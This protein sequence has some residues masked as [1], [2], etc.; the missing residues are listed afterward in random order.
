MR[1]FCFCTDGV[2][3]HLTVAAQGVPGDVYVYGQGANISMRDWVD[4]ILRVGEEHGFWPG[5]RE[6]VSDRCA[7][8][9]GRE[10]GDGA[11]RRAREAHPGDR[12]AAARCRGRT[13]SCTRF[14]GTPRTANAGS[15]ASTGS[16][17]VRRS[18]RNDARSRHRRRRLP[19]LAP[20]GAP[21]ARR[22]RRR[23][24]PQADYDLTRMEDTARMFGDAEAELVFHL[25]AEVGG[26]GANRANPG[27]YWYANLMMGA[28][29]LEQARLHATPKLVVVGTICAYPKLA[30]LPFREEDLWNGYPE[31]TNAPYG[32]AKKALLVGAQAYREQYGL[33]SIYLLPVNLYGPRD[34]FHPDERARHPRPDPQDG[35]GRSGGGEELVLW[36]DGSPTREFLYVDDCVEALRLAAERYDGAD[37]VNVGTGEE[38]SIADLAELIAGLTGFTGEIRW[39]TSKPNG[40]PRRRLDTSRAERAVRVPCA[41]AAARGDRANG[42]VVPLGASGRCRSLA[43][44]SPPPVRRAARSTACSSARG[45]CSASLVCA[46]L[47]GDAPPRAHH[48]AQ[49]LGVLPGRRPDRASTTGWLAGQLDLPPTETAYLWP[50]VQAPVTWVTGPTYVQAVPVAD[51]APGARARPDRRPLHLRDRGE[52]RRAASRVLG[53]A[54][55]GHRAVR[56]DSALHRALPGALDRALPAPGARA[57]RNGRLRVDGARARRG[58]LRA[59]LAVARPAGGRRVLRSADR[60]RRS[61]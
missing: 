34:N 4:L 14:A 44:P 46:Q 12:L 26:I 27:R 1:D 22:A 38:I 37:P 55:V 11:P 18:R 52:D 6:V 20:R 30:P 41:G 9:P 16:R 49:R 28:H 33:N 45:P 40:Q 29:V 51:P 24:R 5:D 23:R 25:A 8:S 15:A 48:P 60:R 54:P 31:E 13:G 39:D 7:L 35:R 21:R 59:P 17:R 43:S 50:F 32:V 36:G 56:R 61:A 19:R 58:A 53:V 10:R 47:A 57:H 2:R 3:G 42:R